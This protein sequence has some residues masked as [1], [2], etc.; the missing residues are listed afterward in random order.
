MEFA[1]MSPHT[2]KLC[3]EDSAAEVIGPV[4]RGDL[5]MAKNG[6]SKSGNGRL[7]TSIGIPE[8]QSWSKFG[9]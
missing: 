9:W 6:A 2:K 1:E 4:D 5:I 3:K 7:A 8:I